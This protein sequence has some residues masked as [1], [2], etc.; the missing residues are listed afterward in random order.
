MQVYIEKRGTSFILLSLKKQTFSLPFGRSNCNEV[1]KH[2]SSRI[3]HTLAMA[4]VHLLPEMGPAEH[5]KP[6]HLQNYF[7][8]SNKLHYEISS[9]DIRLAV[10]DLQINGQMRYFLLN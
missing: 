10:K 7:K 3:S 5:N 9:N 6:T 4:G 8:T 1:S 2:A